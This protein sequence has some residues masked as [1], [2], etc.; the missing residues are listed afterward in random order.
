MKKG[1][2]Q[3]QD[4]IK[5]VCLSCGQANRIPRERLEG[6]P[7]CA[8]CGTSLVSGEVAAIAN[9]LHDKATRTDELPLIVDY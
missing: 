5:L 6:G 2:T 1:G 8:K 7:K 4:A 3:L 9:Q